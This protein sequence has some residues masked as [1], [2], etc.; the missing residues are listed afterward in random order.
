MYRAYSEWLHP[1]FSVSHQEG[2]GMPKPCDSREPLEVWLFF[3]VWEESLKGGSTQHCAPR[4]NNPLE[5]MNGLE[6]VA[7]DT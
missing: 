7:S 6:T 2:E 4:T 3:A 5:S 1:V